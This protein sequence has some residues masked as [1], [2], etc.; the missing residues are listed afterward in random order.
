MA[1]DWREHGMASGVHISADGLYMIKPV[2]NWL[3]CHVMHETMCS[4]G[5][6]RKS[7]QKKATVK[8]YDEARG[9]LEQWKEKQ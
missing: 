2:A 3:E 6:V 4:D 8:S 5:I 9:V 1:I 7:W